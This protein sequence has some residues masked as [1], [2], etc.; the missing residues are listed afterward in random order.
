MDRDY[1][2]IVVGG[3]GAGMSAALTANAAGARVL[4]AE[5]DSELGGSTALSGGAIY[6]AGTSVQRAAGIEDTADAMFE[7]YMT[8]NQYRVEPSLARRLC[9]NGAANVDWLMSLGVE[10]QPE[11][12]C[13]GV[14]SVPRSHWPLEKGAGVATAL[15]AAISR[16]ENIDVVLKC[17][18]QKLL[19][20]D[21]GSCIGIHAQGEPVTAGAVAITTGG[22]GANRNL[23][24]KHYPD[25]A[26]NGDDWSWYIGNPNNVG[27]GLVMAQDVGA[28][29]T[30]HN[31]GL[32]LTTAGFGQDLEVFMPGWLLY[33][34]RE[35]RRF[36]KETAAYGVM[37]G[38]IKAQTGGTCFAVFDEGCRATAEPSIQV[39]AAVK[40]GAVSTSWVPDRLNEEIKKGKIKKADT[41]E[42]LSAIMGIAPGALQA[43]V[44][45]YN[46]DVDAGGDR[47]FFKPHSEMRRI[48]KAPFYAVELRPAI[49][50]LTSTGL[51]IDRD[52]RVLGKDERPIPGLYC[53]GETAGGVFGERYIGS[54]NSVANA[55]GFGRIAGQSAADYGV[56]QAKPA[57]S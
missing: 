34:N 8:I 11:P 32:L 12:N 10:Y 41:L 43:T 27:D 25:A 18:V 5:A 31:R 40:A 42:E 24:H 51:R 16:S 35:G 14:E 52:A 20:D 56:R 17:R 26:G 49:I 48:E 28:D 1:D 9:D 39:A 44:D 3:G 50:C 36:I 47:T 38:V 55:I 22:F 45:N 30:G 46:V 6:A 13:G 4:I 37:S 15:E 54:G 29:I 53:G 21:D 7:Y 19:M 33:I 2:V 57:T 23:L